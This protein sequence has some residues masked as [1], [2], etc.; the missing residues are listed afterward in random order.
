M[1]NN[2]S[3]YEQF[4]YLRRR[5][6][7]E[8]K[9]NYTTYVTATEGNI[10]KNLKYLWSYIS[11]RKANTGIPDT[12]YYKNQRSNDPSIIC[13]LFSNFFESVYEPS[14]FCYMSW[15]PPETYADNCV[16]IN[17]INFSLDEIK[18]HCAT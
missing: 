15:L 2:Q 9:R 10:K 7:I 11:N 12:V 3:D 6:Q 16:V 1:Y 4:S 8:C 13:N 18:K 14:T 17:S 5:F